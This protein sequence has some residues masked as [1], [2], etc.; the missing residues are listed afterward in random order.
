VIIESLVIESVEAEGAGDGFNMDGG[1]ESVLGGEQFGLIG[2]GWQCGFDFGNVVKVN[3]KEL[4]YRQ[5]LNVLSSLSVSC[6]RACFAGEEIELLGRVKVECGDMGELF[7]NRLKWDVRRREFILG[8][9]GVLRRGG[10]SEPVC[11]RRFDYMLNDLTSAQAKVIE[12][13]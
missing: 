8:G 5:K 2:G 7:T 11:G 13:E 12:K 6:A 9:A 1:G 3:I 10:V 4:K